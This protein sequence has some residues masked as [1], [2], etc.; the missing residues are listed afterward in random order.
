LPAH[1]GDQVEDRLRA[2]PGIAVEPTWWMPPSSHG[3]S[4]LELRALGLE[5]IRPGRVVRD[6][7]YHHLSTLA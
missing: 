3:P 6:D 4:T 7:L 2:I 1:A 5:A